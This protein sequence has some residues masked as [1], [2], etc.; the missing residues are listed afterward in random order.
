METTT[1]EMP[2]REWMGR[3]LFDPERG[4]YT[5]GI[6]AIGRGGDFSTSATVGGLLGEGIA[7][8]LRQAARAQRGVRAVIEVGG[9]DGSL[10]A[11]VRTHLGWWRRRRLRWHMVEVS[12]VLQAKQMAR[13][14]RDHVT[15][16]ES[17]SAALEA[18][19]GR[20]FI[21]HNE[22]VDA[23]PVT[24]LQWDAGAAAWREVWVRKEGERWREETR[25]AAVTL[26]MLQENTSLIPERWPGG[27]LRDGQRVELHTSYR[28]WLRSWSGAWREGL[29]LTLDYGA[30]FPQ[31]YHR[32]PRGT[33]RAY[34][35]QQR[36]TGAEVYERMGRQDI[37]SDVNF[38]DVRRWGAEQ[39]WKDL[40]LETQAEF[41]DRHIP[42]LRS[43]AGQDAAAAFVAD[44]DGAGVAFKALVQQAGGQAP[45]A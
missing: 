45:A 40:G 33:L 16:H 44:P 10:A 34:L 32:Q 9:G 29:M 22:L 3:A 24:L 38:S 8:W 1:L 28:E 19:G 4:Y 39:G 15:W 25:D 43:R 23:F 18:C 35:G 27:I 42:G 31:L 14:G 7:G 11:A 5:T 2:F 21:F 20:A 12:P 30:L 6:R 17:M 36:L 26:M 37:T 13:L 41:L